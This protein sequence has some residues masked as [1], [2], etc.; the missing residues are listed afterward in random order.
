MC[1]LRQ[2][3][4]TLSVLG[5][6]YSPLFPTPLVGLMSEIQRIERIDANQICPDIFIRSDVEV[7]VEVEVEVKDKV[8]ISTTG[9]V[10]DSKD[11]VAYQDAYPSSRAISV[12]TGNSQF[13]IDDRAGDDDGVEAV[14]VVHQGSIY[15]AVSS[16]L[17]FR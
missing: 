15:D 13:K 12:S 2:A 17:C 5:S 6:L 3:Q 10:F 16:S 8:E 1:E 11:R 7:E 9:E 14:S 4:E